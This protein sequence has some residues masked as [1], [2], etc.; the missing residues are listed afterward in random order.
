MNSLVES[1]LRSSVVLPYLQALGIAPEQIKSE[2]TFRLLLGKNVAIKGHRDEPEAMVGRLDL[3][4]TNASG[5]NLF[6]MELKRPS[7]PLTEHDV[8]QGI[9]YARLLPQMAPFVLVTN[10]VE[11]R[12]YDTLRGREIQ[13]ED[14]ASRWSEWREGRALAGA[15]DLLIRFEALKHFVGYSVDNVRLFCQAQFEARMARLKGSLRQRDRKYLPELYV[16]RREVADLVAAFLQA[17]SAVFVLAGASGTG[18]TNEMCALAERLAG[19]N[20]VLFFDG[21]ELYGSLAR[22]LSD[23]FNWHFP[24]QLP[25]PKICERMAMLAARLKGHV[26]ILVDAVD[27]SGIPDLQRELSDLTAHMVQFRGNIKLVLSLKTEMWPAFARIKGTPSE[28]S[29]RCFRHQEAESAR[30]VANEVGVVRDP[31]PTLY[32]RRFTS[33]ELEAAVDRYQ[34]VFRLA[35]SFGRGLLEAL[36]DP[37][38]LRVL[39]ETYEGGSVAV[40]DS[41][42]QWDLLRRYMSKKLDNMG[43][44]NEQSLARAALIAVARVL[45]DVTK[46]ES[47]SER[48]QRRAS[49]PADVVDDESIGSHTVSEDLLR[50]PLNEVGASASLAALV[51]HGFLLEVAD[52]EGRQRFVFQYDR[53]RDYIVAAHVHRLDQLSREE[54]EAQLSDWVRSPISRRALQLYVR[55]PGQEHVAS[56]RGWARAWS[57][58][59]V[60]VYDRIRGLLCPGLKQRLLPG[61]AKP[62]GIAYV[63]SDGG[64][65]ALAWFEAP[66]E[67]PRVIEAALISLETIRVPGTS[68]PLEPLRIQFGSAWDLFLRDPDEVAAGSLLEN[69]V[70]VVH[71]GGLDET[72]SDLLALEKA[73]AIIARKRSELG[74]AAR[75]S[76]ANPVIGEMCLDLLP[77]DLADLRRRL[78]SRFGAEFYRREYADGQAKA[79][80]EAA[81]NR[82]EV[83]SSVSI[84]FPPEVLDASRM[85]GAEDAVRGRRFSP[86]N[87][88]PQ[89]PLAV[90]DQTLDVLEKTRSLVSGHYLPGP[91]RDVD[92]H[93]YVELAYNDEGMKEFLAALFAHALQEY[94]RLVEANFGELASR[95]PLLRSFPVVAVIEYGRQPVDVRD[96][97]QDGALTW[98]LARA[99]QE[100]R[101]WVEVYVD[102]NES[103]FV[104]E[105]RGW[106]NGEVRTR[107]GTLRTF[108]MHVTHFSAVVRSWRDVP[109]AWPRGSTVGSELTPVRCWVYERIE[110]EIAGLSPGDVLAFTAGL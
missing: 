69:L 14:L 63:V 99:P 11:G 110:E 9:S 23:E 48:E 37:F 8:E 46:S 55:E 72:T 33:E 31:Q 39:A 47:R 36:A 74:L 77:L 94:Q 90:L 86:P 79:A 105:E 5:D 53:V 60:T 84:H 20:L 73:L 52:A 65:C 25:L 32:L 1:A 17:E 70:R 82:G 108:A 104:K 71:E 22:T 27:E 6:V 4:V 24:E 18:K 40:P 30:E 41:V 61:T 51:T 42:G 81:R 92:G 56:L 50:G 16:P 78:H 43:T 12:L 83:I 58:C 29:E 101:N 64:D 35:G 49:R 80:L 3:L 85:R 34:D 96:P 57:E 88:I 102:E 21:A 15:D 38:L 107:A 62:L 66:D 26:V 100:A 13:G 103:P 54:F 89:D 59:Y 87:V 76:G 67:K 109:L 45:L 93:H 75:R 98:A 91:N 10:G 28:V 95:F 44:P 68:T 97:L 7:E 2:K 106:F 19:E